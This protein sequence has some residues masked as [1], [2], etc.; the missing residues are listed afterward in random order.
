MAQWRKRNQPSWDGP[1]DP[2]TP[3]N[4]RIRNDLPVVPPSPHAPTTPA[5]IGS[6]AVYPPPVQPQ[7]PRSYLPPDNNGNTRGG[8]VNSL[9]RFRLVPG[10]IILEIN[11]E[12]IRGQEDVTSAIARSPQTMYLTV[13]DGRTGATALYVTTLNSSRPRFG[14]THLTHP[15]GGSRVTGVNRTSPATRCYLVE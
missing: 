5:F 12:R 15:G 14:I 6:P 2:Y 10:D 11:G 8:V 4:E 1:F 13:Q 7:P 9:Q 3:K